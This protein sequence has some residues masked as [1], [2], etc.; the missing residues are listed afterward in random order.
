MLLKAFMEQLEALPIKGAELV[1][2]LEQQ[3]TADDWDL[4]ERALR[5]LGS[6]VSLSDSAK[7]FQVH[8]CVHH[9]CMQ[10]CAPTQV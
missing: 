5:A 3:L 9:A 8:C 2:A 1:T 4:S 7:L 6:I 10:H